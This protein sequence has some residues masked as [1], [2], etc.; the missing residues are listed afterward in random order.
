MGV[1]TFE[2]LT[3]NKFSPL[4]SEIKPFLSS[5]MASS[6]PL[7]IAS[8]TAIIELTY[9]PMILLFE[10]SGLSYCWNGDF[11]TEMPFLLASGSI[12]DGHSQHAIATFTES[13]SWDLKPIDSLP[14]KTIGRI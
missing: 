13:E 9:V 8:L 10:Y 7:E 4:P 2:F 3:M 6:A 11:T 1:I 12:Y 5:N 14:K